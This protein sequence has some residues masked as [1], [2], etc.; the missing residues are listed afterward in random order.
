[1]RLAQVRLDAADLRDADFTGV[2][3][4]GGSLA[5]ALLAGSLWL[6]AALLGVGRGRQVEL[7]DQSTS[8]VIRHLTGHTGPVVG[9][10][11]SPD[12]TTVATASG[13]G[14][15]RIWDPATGTCRVTLLPFPGNGY[16]VLLP[17]GSYK[18]SGLPGDSFWWAMKLCRFTPGDLDGYVE[19]IRQLPANAPVL[20]VHPPLPHPTP[21]A[22]DWGPDRTSRSARKR[23]VRR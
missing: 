8:R 14:T 15:A 22:I 2:R 3:L 6:R 21:V 5:G 9:V 16:A 23:G 13:D 4:I 18:L 7:V 20:Q 10:A 17:D 11:F 19:E 12:G 1:M